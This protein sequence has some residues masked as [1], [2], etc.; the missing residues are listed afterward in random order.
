MEDCQAIKIMALNFETRTCTL[1]LQYQGSCR[2][3]PELYCLFASNCISLLEK[4]NDFEMQNNHDF[5]IL[6]N[7]KQQLPKE[8]P[9]FEYMRDVDLWLTLSECQ[10]GAK[11]LTCKSMPCHLKEQ[12]HKHSILKRF[13]KAVIFHHKRTLL[14]DTL[15]FC[16]I[17]NTIYQV[18]MKNGHL[19]S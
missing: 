2:R 12:R 6:V 7:G 17:S 1:W 5:A 3:P 11:Q 9:V 4:N 19:S 8:G 15:V 16:P 13:F 14:S 10:I 18:R